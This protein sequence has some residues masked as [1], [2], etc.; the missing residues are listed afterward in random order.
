MI[1]DSV[2]V[3]SWLMYM[4]QVA[5]LATAQLMLPVPQLV[6]AQ[7]G[8][9]LAAAATSTAGT[10]T[11]LPYMIPMQQVSQLLNAAQLSQRQQQNAPVLATLAKS[12]TGT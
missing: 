2:F 7:G 6:A 3:T 9:Q 1:I 4:L 10:P 5:S 12:S 8:T 11:M